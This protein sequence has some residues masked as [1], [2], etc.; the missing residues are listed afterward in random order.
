MALLLCKTWPKSN[1]LNF[2]CQSID[3]FFLFRYNKKH[4]RQRRRR[5]TPSTSFLFLSKDAA[6]T[7]FLTGGSY[8]Q[9]FF[10]GGDDVGLL[11]TMS[12]SSPQIFNTIN[13]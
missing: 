9:R 13:I 12:G 11:C 7:L 8:V 5:I 4:L 6:I 3:T 2:F 10:I 1:I